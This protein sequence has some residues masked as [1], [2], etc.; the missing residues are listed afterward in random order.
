MFSLILLLTS[1]NI[2]AQSC[3][4]IIIDNEKEVIY[5]GSGTLW[6][7]TTTIAGIYSYDGASWTEHYGQNTIYIGE[8]R[9]WTIDQN[10]IL[11]VA[12]GSDLYFYNGSWNISNFPGFVGDQVNSLAF[13]DNNELW[14]GY[15]GGLGITHW[16]GSAAT[17]YNA[18]NSSLLS[19]E[20]ERIFADHTGT[21]WCWIDNALSGRPK[22]MRFTGSSWQLFDPLITLGSLGVLNDT[23]RLDDP[24]SFDA[25]TNTIWATTWFSNNFLVQLDMTGAVLNLYL[26]DYSVCGGSN[27][28]SK[29]F[30]NLEVASDGSVWGGQNKPFR[31]IN[32]AADC[33]L[34]SF[35]T[36]TIK[37]IGSIMGN[38]SSIATHPSNGEVVA[39]T[40]TG[41]IFYDA[42]GQGEFKN[43]KW[44]APSG[45]GV[46]G[47]F[48]SNYPY[49]D[50]LNSLV[51]FSS[52]GNV[53]ISSGAGVYILENDEWHL[54]TALPE[55][56]SCSG[57]RLYVVNDSVFWLAADSRLLKYENGV[58]VA[59]YSP[60]NS[61]MVAKRPWSLKVDRSGVVY[62]VVVNGD[63]VIFDGSDWDYYSIPN[64][65][66][67]EVRISPNGE[68]YLS[69]FTRSTSPFYKF[70]GLNLVDVFAQQ[71]T[72][73]P[74]EILI[75]DFEFGPD[76]QIWIQEVGIN[77]IPI[78]GN[79][80]GII[81]L[82]DTGWT[83]LGN[84]MDS[85]SYYQGDRSIEFDE[86]G[87]LWRIGDGYSY[88][89][90]TLNNGTWDSLDYCTPPI[91]V[92]AFYGGHHN[93]NFQISPN[94]DKVGFN[95]GYLTIINDGGPGG[96][97]PYDNPITF[98]RGKVFW[99]QNQNGVQDAGEPGLPDR[100]IEKSNGPVYTNTR[101]DGQYTLTE[102]NNSTVTLS[103]NP[104]VNWTTSTPSSYTINTGNALLIDTLS[105]GIYATSNFT[106]ATISVANTFIRCGQNTPAWVSYTNNGTQIEDGSIE[107]NIDS[108]ITFVGSFPL[109]NTGSSQVFTWNYTNLLPGE[110]RMINVY[111]NGPIPD[112]GFILPGDTLRYSAE[113]STAN[114]DIDLTNNVNE[115]TEALRCAYD[116][117][118]KLVDK[119]NA[120]PEGYTLLGDRLTY[121]IRFQNTGNDTAFNV[122]IVDTLDAV[123]MN[124]LTLE[125]IGNSHPMEFKIAGAGVLTFT[126]AN[127]MLPD[128]GIDFA[129]SNGFVQFAI[130]PR[131]SMA[132]GTKVRN[133]AGIYFDFNPAIVTNT[134]L[135]TFVTKLPEIVKPVSVKQVGQLNYQLYPNPTDAELFISL[136]NGQYRFQ[137]YDLSGKLLREEAFI[138][139]LKKLDVSELNSGMY[140]YKLKDNIGQ[141]GQGSV[142]IK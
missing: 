13:D 66:F 35:P 78:T 3:T 24:I 34:D 89:F 18:G 142:V 39:A 20:V 127:I 65:K 69:T 119:G 96:Y 139:G 75:T 109:V 100:I 30:H 122:V 19:N 22:H 11:Y 114:T 55:D 41:L 116:P 5:D 12:L 68:A 64:T 133:T 15:E 60:Q 107:L 63:L 33:S 54:H 73:L 27:S 29:F 129:K 79:T 132:E 1:G 80:Q 52:A 123:N 90:F 40:G 86:S 95:G 42:N 17:N 138:G 141:T 134:T 104:P 118:D 113:I 105:F 111:L 102:P 67:T 128:S 85:I 131:D 108:F 110:D 14:V 6:L 103:Y 38:V 8:F 51:Q 125:V 36:Q 43:P 130:S 16:D 115:I 87:T 97:N 70:D 50:A 101:N 61:G 140:F 74:D 84:P 25:N 98:L 37:C 120:W 26:Y 88:D 112:T 46:I 83:L 47:A 82:S 53:M 48:G 71:A 81:V 99:D 49:Q 4:T 126:F 23:T 124:P 32:G 44:V 137:L 21:I 92:S 45:G 56:L 57:S 10:G 59:D 62:I 106:D 2:S 77:I 117:N 72:P 28:G 94:G 136:D 135:N 31:H 121:T 76:G 7:A 9:A 91:P 58:K 93:I